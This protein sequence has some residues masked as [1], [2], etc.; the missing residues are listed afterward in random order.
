VTE[1]QQDGP[2]M[3]DIYQSQPLEDMNSQYEMGLQQGQW[4][5]TAYPQQYVP[6]GQ[7]I[8]GPPVGYYPPPYPMISYTQYWAGY[9]PPQN[10]QPGQLPTP[11]TSPPK[12]ADQYNSG[13]VATISNTAR[14]A[15]KPEDKKHVC[16]ICPK[17]F[18]RPSALETHQTTHTGATPFR[19]PIVDCQRHTKGFSVKS[20][21]IRHCRNGHVEHAE[22]LAQQR[23]YV[24]PKGKDTR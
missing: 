24:S 23:I 17:T 3:V 21:M 4:A 6:Q 20:N 2:G 8:S 22:F 9:G 7:P 19:C 12:A 15:R 10:Q 18:L 11:S 13:P 16:G 14:K 1:A 5:H